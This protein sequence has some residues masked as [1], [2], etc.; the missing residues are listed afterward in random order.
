MF[1]LIIRAVAAILVVGG[2]SL[3]NATQG[4][5]DSNLHVAP[6][7]EPSS[8]AKPVHSAES[9]QS[10]ET[11]TEPEVFIQEPATSVEPETNLDSSP[12]VVT[13]KSTKT[14]ADVARTANETIFTTMASQSGAPWGLDKLDG[15][16][17]N[18]Y[19]YISDGTGVRIYIVDTGVNA[20]H[21]EFGSRVIDGYD[22]FGE[23]LDQTDCDGH[24]T[25]VAGI[26][27]GNYYGVAKAATIVPVR[28]MDCNGVGNT[29]TLTSGI[30]WILANHSGGTGI[31]NMSIGGRKDELVDSAVSRLV[32]AGMIVVAAAGNSNVDACGISPASAPGVIAVGAT[33]QSDAKT[34]FSN[35]GQCVDISAPGDRINSANAA[36]D[37]ISLRMSGTSQASPFVAGAIA[38][39]LSSGFLKN[40]AEAQTYVQQLAVNGV[41]RVQVEPEESV[42]PIPAP[43]VEPEPVTPEPEPSIP[44]AVDEPIVPEYDVSV[45]A[46]E[47][48]PMF[49]LLSWSQISSSSGYKIYR[50]SPERPTW[51]VYG[52]FT[53]NLK[54]EMLIVTDV[55]KFARYRV[56]A[57]VDS[58]EIEIGEITHAPVN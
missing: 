51:K 19:N 24:G 55:G 52:A 56:V 9:T 27:A 39:Y 53:N 30:N 57:I 45:I 41:V 35:W 11:E 21:R 10:V 1:K 2:L 49:G 22:A 48:G 13:P 47:D 17:D 8:L 31:V 36:D 25:H 38:T 28:V 16:R 42:E 14:A 32:S 34:S 7:S 40:P 15:T 23:N 58:K 26:A 43:V 46:V 44:P 6:V 33:D 50:T 37:N 20:T 5:Q 4:S 18:T 54:T 3:G 29:T 12:K